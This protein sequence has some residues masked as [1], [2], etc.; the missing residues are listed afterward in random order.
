[1]AD[2]LNLTDRQ[3]LDQSRALADVLDEQGYHAADVLTIQGYVWQFIATAAKVPVPNDAMKCL[4][5]SRLTE[6][7]RLSMTDPL[8]GLPK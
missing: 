6:R 8:D 2:I 7:E 4:V 1:M 3:R 5:H